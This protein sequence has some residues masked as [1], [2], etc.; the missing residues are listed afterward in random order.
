[1]L[2]LL[3][4]LVIVKTADTGAFA[5][6]KSFGR[7]KM[8]PALSPGK[9]WEGSIGG[10]ATAGLASWAMFHFAGPELVGTGYVEPPLLAALAYGLL[11]GVAGIIGDLAESLLK[12][13]MERKDSS[14]WL[15]GLGGVLDIID[16]VL[17]AG[18]VAWL[19]WVFG[20][21]GPGI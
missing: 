8:T 20:L 17:V 9:T 12:R 4:L 6:G 16:S 18:P 11:L 19:C 13:D 5:F 2:A 3:S 21:V 10:L 7:H 15:P 1:M 14:S